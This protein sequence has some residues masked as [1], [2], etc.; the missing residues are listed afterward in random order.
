MA[1]QDKRAKL[2]EEG[3]DLLRSTPKSAVTASSCSTPAWNFPLFSK[4]S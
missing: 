1:T 4:S 2:T 3:F